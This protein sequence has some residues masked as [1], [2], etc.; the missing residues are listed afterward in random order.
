MDEEVLELV[1]ISY[2]DAVS[3]HRFLPIVQMFDEPSDVEVCIP[4]HII[5]RERESKLKLFSLRQHITIYSEN[6]RSPGWEMNPGIK[7]G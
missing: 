2:L 6:Y 7:G 1:G 5:E 4:L 3:L